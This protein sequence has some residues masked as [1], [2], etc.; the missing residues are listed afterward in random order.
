MMNRSEE[1]NR[2]LP[3]NATTK[4]YPNNN[5]NSYKVLLPVTLDLEGT[6]VV[7]IVNI[8]YP[9]NWPKFNEE[10]VAFMVSVKESEPE[11]ET[12]K[13]QEATE[14][15]TP[16]AY[17]KAQFRLSSMQPPLD[18]NAKTLSLWE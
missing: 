3:S 7:A 13:E 1:F 4:Y 6:W 8:Q 16:L 9:F 14:G 15:D 17:F 10:F 12:Q 5:P 18:R 2:T 11:K